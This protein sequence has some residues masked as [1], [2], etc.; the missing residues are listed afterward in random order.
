MVRFREILKNYDISKFPKVCLSPLP[1]HSVLSVPGLRLV[2]IEFGPCRAA[3][4]RVQLDMKK[5]EEMDTALSV[6][7][8]NLLRLLPGI[9][10][11]AKAA[12]QAQGESKAAGGAGGAGAA[13]ADDSILNPFNSDL[14]AV[15]PRFSV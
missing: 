2:M 5:V 4:L 15:G 14:A 8:P 6:E 11:D 1:F 10:E 13:G 12:A 9:G 3:M 7:I